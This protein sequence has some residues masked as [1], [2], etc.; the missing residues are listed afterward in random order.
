MFSQYETRTE[1]KEAAAGVRS[2]LHK[3]QKRNN[4]CDK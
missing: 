1:N 3:L 4:I 2:I